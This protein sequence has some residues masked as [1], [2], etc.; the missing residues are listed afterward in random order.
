MLIGLGSHENA[1][2]VSL[3]SSILLARLV[4]TCKAMVA[5]SLLRYYL[6]SLTSR[7]L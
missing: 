5:S 2:G 1:V 7:V 4:V 3:M 6:L